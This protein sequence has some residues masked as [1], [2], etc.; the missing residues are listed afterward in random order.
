MSYGQWFFTGIKEYG[1]GFK[2]YH[3]GTF[4]GLY[5]TRADARKALK[6]YA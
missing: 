5:K 1:D 6:A 4:V 2:A 3:D